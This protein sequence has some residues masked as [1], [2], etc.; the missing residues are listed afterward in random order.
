MNYKH[1]DPEGAAYESNYEMS[2]LDQL[3]FLKDD[4]LQHNSLLGPFR[5]NKMTTVH[6]VNKFLSTLGSD[7]K[8]VVV[9][10]DPLDCLYSWF[11]AKEL[12]PG[13]DN[14]DVKK[15][16]SISEFVLQ[17]SPS[18]HNEVEGLMHISK[19]FSIAHYS[20]HDIVFYPTAWLR[21]VI[22]HLG[23]EPSSETLA[24]VNSLMAFLNPYESVKSH[25]RSGL[26]GS[27][28]LSIG[29]E[30]VLQIDKLY[31]DFNSKFGYPK[32][33]SDEKALS[34]AYELA[35]LRDAIQLLMHK[36]GELNQVILKIKSKK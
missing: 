26:P 27:A 18:Y 22:K 9:T 16:V 35:S 12:H 28:R 31:N 15:D 13:W 33:S 5:D 24:V 19:D 10:R 32:P 4:L 11:Y 36:N 14:E 29:R 17:L 8:C 1:Y 23:V 20:Y 2:T 30:I 3:T 34:L 6:S 21:A 25:R 7:V